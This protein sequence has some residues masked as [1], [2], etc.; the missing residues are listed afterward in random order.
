MD[1]LLK[2]LY[3][4]V[5]TTVVCVENNMDLDVF[6]CSPAAVPPATMHKHGFNGFS[7]VKYS[8]NRCNLSSIPQVT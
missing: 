2:G 6:Q 5:N 7:P 3:L 4:K 1:K 8:P